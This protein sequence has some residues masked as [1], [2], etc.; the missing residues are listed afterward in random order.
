MVF[1]CNA[2]GALLVL[3]HLVFVLE[4]H[5]GYVPTLAA[6]FLQLLSEEFDRCYDVI[7]NSLLAHL[8]MAVVIK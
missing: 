4:C 5:T 6:G 1:L 2:E 3:S 8:W 7:L